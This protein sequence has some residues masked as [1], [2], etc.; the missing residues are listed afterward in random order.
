MMNI[1]AIFTMIKKLLPKGPE[2]S[3]HNTT[4]DIALPK[5]ADLPSTYRI[6]PAKTTEQLRQEE[7][8]LQ[9]ALSAKRLGIVDVNGP[10][11]SPSIR[12]SS[13]VS[14]RGSTIAH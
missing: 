8:M 12:R 14:G 1:R 10:E 3:I 2:P 11:R 5:A 6:E 7:T 9:A 4:P 13:S